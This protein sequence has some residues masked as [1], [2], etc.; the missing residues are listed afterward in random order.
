VSKR[1]TLPPKRKLPAGVI[2]IPESDD[3][4]IIT[5]SRPKSAFLVLQPLST[6]IIRTKKRKVALPASV[7]EIPDSEEDEDEE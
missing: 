5:S 2:E 1:T 4:G 7:I 3:E 6:S